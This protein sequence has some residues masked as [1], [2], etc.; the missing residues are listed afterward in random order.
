MNKRGIA[1]LIATLLLLSFAVALGVVIMQF[2]RAQ[3]E[4]EAQCPIEIGLRFAEISGKTDVCFDGTQVRYTVEN[5]VNIDV[6]GLIVNVI[7]TEK[8]ETFEDNAATMKK[9][10]TYVGKMTYNKAI[11]GEIRQVKIAPK[12]MMFEE[13]QICQ[14]KSLI[15]E[16]I[17]PC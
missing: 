4:L 6:S 15:I 3:V 5:G 11:A 17:P 10:G 16:D 8:A 7:G 2:G 1:P 14:E 13:E 9:A 12:V